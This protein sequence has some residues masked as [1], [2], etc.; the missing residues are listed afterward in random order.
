MNIKQSDLRTSSLSFRPS[1]LIIE[2]S[3]EGTKLKP[4][5]PARNLN[6]CTNLLPK[7]GIKLKPL[8]PASNLNL[9]NDLNRNEVHHPT[10]VKSLWT[11]RVGDMPKLLPIKDDWKFFYY[12]ED[13][14]IHLKTLGPSSG[15][16]MYTLT[17]TMLV[18]QPH[19]QCVQGGKGNNHWCKSEAKVYIC[20]YG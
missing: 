19:R 3:R 10:S 12:W 8:F 7:E 14:R 18:H 5:F 13:L 1:N 16:R 20:K 17:M 9:K 11:V 15:V 6:F 2:L 4:P